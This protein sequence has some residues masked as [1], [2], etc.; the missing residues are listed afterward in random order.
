MENQRSPSNHPDDTPAAAPGP[1]YFFV[2]GHYAP[3]GDQLQWKR[4]FWAR[5]QAGWDWNPARWVRAPA[6]GISVRLL[7]RRPG[8]VSRTTPTVVYRGA[9]TR[10]PSTPTQESTAPFPT[11]TQDERDVIAG[12]KSTSIGT[13]FHDRRRAGAR[14]AI[15]RD[16]PPRILSLWTRRRGR[17]RRSAA[18]R[19]TASRPGFALTVFFDD[20]IRRPNIVG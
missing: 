4:G 7:G 18:V 2:P 15:L 20:C 17:A 1:D 6:G 10:E 12:R 8:W 5:A 9:T 13:G 14:N 16:P 11:G 3:V 19:P